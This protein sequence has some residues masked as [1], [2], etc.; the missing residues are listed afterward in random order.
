MPRSPSASA[1]YGAGLEYETPNHP[2]TTIHIPGHTGSN[3]EAAPVLTLYQVPVPDSVEVILPNG[4]TAWGK[5]VE[6]IRPATTEPAG[7]PMPA[8]AKSFSMVA[9]SLGG[10]SLSF[11]LALR[12]ARPAL[13]DLVD[14]LEM[15]MKVAFFLA[16]ILGVIVIAARSRLTANRQN[17]GADQA[18]GTEYPQQTVVVT[19]E[20]TGGTRLLGRSGDVNVQL[21][22]RARYKH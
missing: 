7:Q 11:A 17:P 2:P 14:L 19:V 1:A 12:I 10:L 21:G 13:G 9:A 22:D 4:A 20:G 16:V 8:W 15:A 18:L 6:P 3:L 5:Y